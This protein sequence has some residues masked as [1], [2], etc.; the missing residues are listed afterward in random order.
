MGQGLPLVLPGGPWAGS[1]GHLRGLLRAWAAAHRA[2]PGA[3]EMAWELGVTGLDFSPSSATD[4]QWDPRTV[5][6]WGGKGLG[7]R[8]GLCKGER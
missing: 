5:G 1:L 6:E 3:R 4:W 7:N 2:R 8:Q